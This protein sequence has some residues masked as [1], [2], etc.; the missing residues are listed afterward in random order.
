MTTT[1]TNGT[2]ET[3][4]KTLTTEEKQ[5]LWAA[6]D[7]AQSNYEAAK[8]ELEACKENLSK[9]AT[10]IVL[11]TG[12]TGFNRSGQ[13]IK[14]VKRKKTNTYTVRG[15]REELEQVDV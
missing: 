3:E 1:E 14:F 9:A 5:S 10:A 11:A 6:L 7:D 15:I 12:K 13:P 2:A 8:A 4:L